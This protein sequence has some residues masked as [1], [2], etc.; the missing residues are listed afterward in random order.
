MPG[1]TYTC[2][3]AR[4]EGAPTRDEEGRLIEADRKPCGMDVTELIEEV[5]WDGEVHSVTCPNCGTETTVRR[6]AAAE[7]EAS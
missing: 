7:S 1:T 2:R 6:S 4:V 5:P 3:G